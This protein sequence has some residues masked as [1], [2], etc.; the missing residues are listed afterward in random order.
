MSQCT[1]S[2]QISADEKGFID[3]QCPSEEC[4]VVFKVN[5]TDWKNLFRDEEV[6]CPQ[7]RHAAPADTGIPKPRFSTS[8]KKHEIMWRKS[9]IKCWKD[10][11][12]TSIDDNSATPSS[13]CR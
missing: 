1:F 11:L 10:L 12:V 13:Q 9:S 5:S 2:I 3:R 4:L 6:F 7:C 8:R